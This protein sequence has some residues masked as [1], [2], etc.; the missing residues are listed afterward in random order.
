MPTRALLLAALVAAAAGTRNW[1]RTGP[2]A[3]VVGTPR[4]NTPA[5]DVR[6]GIVTTNDGI[7]RPRVGGQ[8][9]QLLVKEGDAVKKDQLVAVINPD[10]LRADTAY[11][12]PDGPGLASQVRAH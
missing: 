4:G 3:P 1:C 6:T 8:I 9:G 5:G 10:E 7:V 11:Y 12:A 2:D